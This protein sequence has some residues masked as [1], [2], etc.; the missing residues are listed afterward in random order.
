MYAYNVLRYHH[1]CTYTS[2]FLVNSVLTCIYFIPLLEQEIDGETLPMLINCGTIEQLHACGLKTIKE[3]MQLR[4]IFDSTIKPGHNAGVSNISTL[5]HTPS[6]VSTCTIST[7]KR[8]KKL[9][10]TEINQLSPEENKKDIFNEM[11]I[12]ISWTPA[13]II[14]CLGKGLIIYNVCTAYSR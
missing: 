3:Q 7:P 9:S 10:I 12:V 13:E 4:K 8:V 11:S 2:R 6:S 14:Y 1:M 5:T